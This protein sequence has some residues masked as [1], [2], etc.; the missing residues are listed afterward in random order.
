MLEKFLSDRFKMIKE[1][2]KDHLEGLIE[3]PPIRE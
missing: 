2:I 3:E 1:D